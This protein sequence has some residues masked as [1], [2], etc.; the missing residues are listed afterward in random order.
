MPGVLLGSFD[1]FKFYR[2]SIISL[3]FLCLDTLYS[4]RTI[5]STSFFKKVLSTFY[6]LLFHGIVRISSSSYMH[7]HTH[8][9]TRMHTFTNIY[10]LWCDFDIYNMYLQILECKYDISFHSFNCSLIFQ[11]IFFIL[12]LI[13]F[14]ETD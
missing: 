1:L 13:T 4:R 9:R 2:I 10:S 14:Y 5:S 8:T 3:A 11:Y 6:T 7:T 12:F